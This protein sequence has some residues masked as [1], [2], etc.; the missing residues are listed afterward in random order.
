MKRKKEMMDFEMFKKIIDQFSWLEYI[1]LQNW[2]EPLLQPKIFDMI[3][4]AKD[5]GIKVFMYTN[6][7][8]LTSEKIKQLIDSGIDGITIS[9][10][11]Y[12]KTYEKIRGFS[13]DE[14][15]KKIA[16][17]I[18]LRNEKNSSMFIE[19][20][21]VMFDETENELE[22]FKKRWVGVADRVVVQPK[23]E[24]NE[25]RI[26]RCKELWR[27]NIIVLSNGLVVPCCY[28][29]EGVMVIGDAKKQNIKEIWNGEIIKRI[30]DQHNKHNFTS[31]CKGCG[32]FK[33]KTV[34][35]RFE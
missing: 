9:I 12:G 28:D 21:M 2:G 27:G 11:G 10:D 29:Y 8:L 14:I 15:G 20:S 33:A 17:L 19:V 18:K 23:L 1:L 35:P 16:D 32:E 5:R 34:K 24:Y 6:G 3:K 7:T 4:Y 13:Y 25:K 22:Q 30:R 26:T 31:L